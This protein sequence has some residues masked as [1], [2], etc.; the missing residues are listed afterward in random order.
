MGN[1]VIPG[2]VLVD[3]SDHLPNVIIMKGT[4]KTSHTRERPKVRI[5]SER[6]IS[7]FIHELENITWENQ[8]TCQ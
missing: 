6:N 2:N 1:D 3:I 8:M 5:F 4:S 7:S